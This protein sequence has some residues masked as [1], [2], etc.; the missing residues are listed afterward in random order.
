MAAHLAFSSSVTPEL[1]GVIFVFS[2][3]L[4]WP[5]I[6]RTGMHDEGLQYKH[7]LQKGDKNHN[8]LKSRHQ[9]LKCNSL[10]CPQWVLNDILIR[11]REYG[12]KINVK[13]LFNAQAARQNTS[14]TG[15]ITA[16]IPREVCSHLLTLVPRSPIFLPWRWRRYVPPKRRFEQDYTAPHPRRRHS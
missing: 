3:F 5:Y 10:Y 6:G 12:G 4:A 14:L 11:S 2:H 16:I 7:T 8:Y 13:L 15:N 1:K 9:R